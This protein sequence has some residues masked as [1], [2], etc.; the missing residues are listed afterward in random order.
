MASPRY[1]NDTHFSASAGNWQLM[2]DRLTASK[3]PGGS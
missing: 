3:Y 1:C 2:A